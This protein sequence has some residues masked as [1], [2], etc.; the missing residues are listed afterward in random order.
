MNFPLCPNHI[1]LGSARF[2]LFTNVM[3]G[4]LQQKD[5]T[6]LLK[7]L[8]V[9]CSRHVPLLSSVIRSKR[10]HWSGPLP[11]RLWADPRICG[12][13]T[14]HSMDL[15][16]SSWS[17]WWR[18]PG[19]HG[20]HQGLRQCTETG[21]TKT[22]TSSLEPSRC[23]KSMDCGGKHEQ[24]SPSVRWSLQTC[25][26]IL[27]S[28]GLPRDVDVGILDLFSIYL[29]TSTCFRSHRKRLLLSATARQ[30]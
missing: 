8:S 26:A 1:L 19:D 16:W 11:H 13:I 23:C 24:K 25:V 14:F 21:Q 10:R 28:R 30:R 15:C 27:R 17:V 4:I 22:N 9:F 12:L 2:S 3:A 6:I 29:C 7:I 5:L 18:K 20:S